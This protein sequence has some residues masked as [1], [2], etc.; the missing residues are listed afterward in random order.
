[1]ESPP[2]QRSS[3]GGDLTVVGRWFQD[4]DH[5]GRRTGAGV[6]C[7]HASAQIDRESGHAVACGLDA[8]PRAARDGAD[9][10]IHFENALGGRRDQQPAPGRVKRRGPG[11]LP[12]TVQH[13]DF[14]ARLRIHD[15]QLPVRRTRVTGRDHVQ[16]AVVPD[17]REAGVGPR[18][19]NRIRRPDGTAVERGQPAR[20]RWGRAHDIAV[21][22]EH[23]RS[24][25]RYR[26]RMNADRDTHRIAN[27]AIVD[28]RNCVEVGICD[29]GNR[30]VLNGDPAR[31][32]SRG[33]RQDVVWL[34]AQGSWRARPRE[35][36]HTYRVRLP[37]R[38]EKDVPAAVDRA[39]GGAGAL[40]IPRGHGEIRSGNERE[41]A[42][43]RVYDADHLPRRAL[44]LERVAAAGHETERQQEEPSH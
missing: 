15:R 2:R 21:H 27:P 17:D 18:E 9:G 33:K 6:D 24:H 25:D 13:R 32:R 19:R 44:L 34:H 43:A 8:I 12:Q 39:R 11:R 28:P 29:P 26:L 4:V 30:V 7:V 31:S 20:A 38:D 42:R 37:Q 10:G 14:D 3:D 40:P 22:D 1:M 5:A 16:Q 35:E 36:I 41:R 23:P